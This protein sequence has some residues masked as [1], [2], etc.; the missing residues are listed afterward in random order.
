[1]AGKQPRATF[2]DNAAIVRD[3]A[4]RR[5]PEILSTVGGIP[6]TILDGR[7]HPCPK[8]GGKDRFRSFDD[9]DESGGLICNQCGRTNGDGIASIQWAC[10]I[11]FK[12]ALKR[13]ADHLGVKLEQRNG[14]PPTQNGQ[15]SPLSLIHI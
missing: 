5:W 10:G 12:E 6:T 9:F 7:H 13:I 4:A 11:D 15:T 3:A 1:M 14:K 2:P 8:C